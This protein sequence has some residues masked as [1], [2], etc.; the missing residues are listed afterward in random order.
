MGGT[1]SIVLVGSTSGS[2]TLQEPAVAGSNTINLPAATGTAV[3]TGVSGTVDINA[4]GSNNVTLSTNSTERMRITSGGY[5]K[6]SNSG[7]Y[8][9]AAGS[10]HELYNDGNTETVVIRNA[11]ASFNQEA[12]VINVDRNTTNNSYYFLR[13]NVPGVGTRFLIADSGAIGTA[14]GISLGNVTPPTSGIGVK[15]PAT[16]SASSDVNTLD[17]YEEGTWTP[18]VIG[19]TTAGTAT[20]TIQRGRYT[21][22][23]NRVF[24]TCVVQ[25]NSG[26]GTGSLGVTGL[27]FTSVNEGDIPFAPSET[28]D[29]AWTA[30]YSFAPVMIGNSTSVY[31]NQSRVG[32][33]GGA[34]NTPYDSA[35]YISFL[36]SYVAA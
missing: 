36:G 34:A 30:N 23:G 7:N 11:N 6:M 4:A 20:Y 29:I 14:G 22:I 31:C 18:T 19:T 35:G 2:I 9:N 33:S 28:S 26:T 27:P 3:L 24:V 15:F 32:G 10:Y 21:K 8:G 12:V 25:Y 5:T 17:D 13:G 1:M 16:Q